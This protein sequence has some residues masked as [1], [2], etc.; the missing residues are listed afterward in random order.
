VARGS[1]WSAACALVPPVVRGTFVFAAGQAGDLVA[2]EILSRAAAGLAGICRAALASAGLSAP[3]TATFTG[4]LLTEPAGGFRRRI[5]EQLLE[6]VV[7]ACRGAAADIGLAAQL[8]EPLPPGRLRTPLRPLLHD[9][10]M[11]TQPPRIPG[12]LVA[13]R[14]GIGIYAITGTRPIVAYVYQDPEVA[15]SFERGY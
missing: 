6:L 2:G 15:E 3:V 8:H 7:S 11:T 13:F 9:A 12:A 10:T 14:R 5:E 1:D 4:S